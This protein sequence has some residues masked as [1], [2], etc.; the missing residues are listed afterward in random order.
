MNDKTRELRLR[1]NKK[2]LKVYY[3]YGRSKYRIPVVRLA[4]NYL[5]RLNFSIGDMV[6]VCM[7]PGVITIRKISRDKS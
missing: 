6:E 4:G 3:G 2:Y 1:N 5:E 7:E